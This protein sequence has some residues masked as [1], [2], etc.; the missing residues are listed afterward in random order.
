MRVAATVL[1]LLLGTGCL[2]PVR[3]SVYATAPALPPT[4]APVAVSA[5]RDPAGARTLGVV[6]A[7]GHL[8]A[9]TLAALVSEFRARV[10]SMG[11]DFGRIDSFA[12]RHEMVTETYQYD[13]GTDEI[14]HETRTVFGT[15][16]DGTPT[17]STETVPVVKHVP[18]TCTGERVVE[19]ATLALVGRA[20]LTEGR[21]P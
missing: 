7:S 14:D 21:S 12:T 6:E 15:A 3:S 5:T 16:P 18:K 17:V 2:A 19:V 11:G 8:P 1:P 20:L 10:A 9:A 4:T 13:C